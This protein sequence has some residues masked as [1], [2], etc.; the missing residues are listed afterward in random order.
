M[1]SWDRRFQNH[2]SPLPLDF[3]F[4]HYHCV[5]SAAMAFHG[6]SNFVDTA[7]HI[8][9]RHQLGKFYNRNKD[10]G[11]WQGPDECPTW[12]PG[13]GITLDVAPPPYV[14]QWMRHST[15]S[16]GDRMIADASN[17]AGG[18][19][20][21]NTPPG[22]NTTWRQGP[23]PR[24][25]QAKARLATAIILSI[26]RA[27]QQGLATRQLVEE[28]YELGLQIRTWQFARPGLQGTIK[29]SEL[30][31]GQGREGTKTVRTRRRHPISAGPWT[32]T[33]F[34]PNIE[35]AQVSDHGHPI[36]P[37][38][39]HDAEGGF[40]SDGE[41]PSLPDA[42]VAKEHTRRAKTLQ[43]QVNGTQYVSR[44]PEQPLST[45]VWRG[46]RLDTVWEA[47]NILK[48]VAHTEPG[49][50]HWMHHWL[51]LLAGDTTIARTAGQVYLLA[52][53]SNATNEYRA[54]TTGSARAPRKQHLDH[55]PWL[56]PSSKATPE[57]PDNSRSLS[58]DPKPDDDIFMV[59]A[60]AMVRLAEVDAP[61]DVTT[62]PLT[63]TESNKSAQS[64]T[65]TTF[66]EA[67]KLYEEMDTLY[68]LL[69]F[70]V[71][72][73]LFARIGRAVRARPH[74][75]DVASWFTANGLFPERPNM[76]TSVERAKFAEIAWRILCVE[77]VYTRMAVLREYEYKALPLEHYPFA[78]ANIN[79]SHVV[80]YAAL[81]A[82][83]SFARARRNTSQNR[84]DPTLREFYGPQ[85]RCPADA[86]RIIADNVI[87]W[88]ELCHVPRAGVVTN[89]PEFPGK[90]T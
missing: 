38:D 76:G 75:P 48:W 49:A 37:S 55:R 60:K 53:Q 83:E 56:P 64:A 41:E 23:R 17:R 68:W 28:L 44:H 40:L 66:G 74:C 47:A 34:P 12:V 84:S 32:Q 65:H 5:H 88:S 29:I 54:I 81:A 62:T 79:G 77:G 50:Y 36:F 10:G 20:R 13:I 80:A 45:G 72:E 21:H 52:H 27:A 89:Y 14:P 7:T 63:E 61:E 33:V 46:L 30:H 82:L 78:T 42:W 67:M 58:M 39:A 59:D 85:P 1:A 2:S 8:Q 26:P 57:P 4:P 43:K 22:Y 6:N 90:T 9:A 69:G 73:L 71:S 87:H 3:P 31:Q 11:T 25:I 86:A 15:L 24:R 51:V 19:L 70:R 35:D 18:R 16:A